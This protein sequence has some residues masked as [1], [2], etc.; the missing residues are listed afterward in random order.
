MSFPGLYVRCIIE[1]RVKYAVGM[2]IRA[3]AFIFHR[4][5][6]NICLMHLK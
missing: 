5:T 4:V 6:A 2:A 1:N 3:I